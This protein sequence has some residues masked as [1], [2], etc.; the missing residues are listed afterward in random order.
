MKIL[1]VATAAALVASPALAQTL[2]SVPGT[3]QPAASDAGTQ[4]TGEIK[5]IDAK[6]GTVTIHHSPI[7]ALSWPA[8]T[9]TFKATPDA[10]KSAKPG[11]R[12]S[13]TLKGPGSQVVAIEPK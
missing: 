6:A 12:V 1:L 5:S 4:A 8:M 7:R 11:Q 3:G 2:G 10:L 13:F 9:M